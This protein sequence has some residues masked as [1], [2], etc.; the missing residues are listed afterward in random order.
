MA[1]MRS[2]SRL[3]WLHGMILLSAVMGCKGSGCT[4]G[5]CGPAQGGPAGGTPI[6]SG[7]NGT[8]GVGYPKLFG[9]NSAP[10]TSQGMSGGQTYP[11]T[12]GAQGAYPLPASSSTTY[13]GFGG[14]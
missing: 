5:N 4:G 9:N 13:P 6:I 12:P 1:S 8:G 10:S 7:A 11:A 3:G 2:L 14:Q